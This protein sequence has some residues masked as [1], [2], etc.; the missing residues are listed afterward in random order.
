MDRNTIVRRL[1]KI[2]MLPT[3]P[4][5]VEEV[6]GIIDDPM[7]SASDLAKHMDPS[8]IGEI[9]R[10]ANTAYFGTRN[11]R[12]ISTIEHAIAVI[13]Y[14]HLTHVVLQMPFLHM[15][16]GSDKSF[17][18][19]EFVRHSI[20]CG[21]AAKALS[22]AA[23]KGDSSQ[24]Y[25][26]GIMH[27]VGTIIMYRYFRK[28]W[29]Q[30]LALI[31]DRSF[32]RFEA[33]RQVFSVDHGYIGAALL[34]LWNIP[35]PI[36]EGVMFHHCPEEASDNRENALVV[37]VGNVFSRTIDFASDFKDFDIFVA[38]HRLTLEQI[39]ALGQE[40]SPS[41]EIVFLER[42][43][44]L[45]KDVKGYIENAVEGENDKGSCS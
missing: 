30:V 8:M 24:I 35:R 40:T 17:D 22:L 9:L 37:S 13:G 18:R 36:T 25:L 2:D 42:I 12:N 1:R 20:L 29:D 34:E 41:K 28:E 38:K 16:N 26:S 45:L 10:I 21:V 31:Q 3:F 32:P 19:K 27:D 33:E 11:F 23:G 15:V 5:I 43:Y 6:V 44:L 4:H 39:V 7:S 14:E